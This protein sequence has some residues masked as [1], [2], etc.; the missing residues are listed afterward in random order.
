[1]K[2]DILVTEQGEYKTTFSR[3]YLIRK[4]YAPLNIKNVISAIPGTIIKLNIALK[5]EVAEGDVLLELD[6]MKMH[7]K[8]LAPMSGIIKSI[9]VTEGV[10]VPKNF[11]MV[12]FE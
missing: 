3:K 9:H 5:D 4:N 2:Y 10:R 11:L 7:N 12:E 1:M 6:A 8:I